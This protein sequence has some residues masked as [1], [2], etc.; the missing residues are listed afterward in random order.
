MT[1]E[2]SEV[3]CIIH[4]VGAVAEW[5]R[6]G[7]QNRVHRFEPGRCLHETASATLGLFHGA[8]RGVRTGGSADEERS[9]KACWHV[10]SASTAGRRF[11]ASETDTRSEARAFH[12]VTHIVRSERC[13][14]E[15]LRSMPELLISMQMVNCIYE[16]C[17]RMW[18]KKV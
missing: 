17:C 6:S 7:L 14:Y 15:G 2:I 4:G 9:E 12:G 1:D 5:L 3:I 10:F 18:I 16:I 13:A 8:T 11:R